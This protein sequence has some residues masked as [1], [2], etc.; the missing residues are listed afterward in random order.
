M[1]VETTLAQEIRAKEGKEKYDAACKRLLSQKSILAWILKSCVEE[2]RDCSIT[3]IAEKYIEGT[4]QISVVPVNPDETNAAPVI[5]GIRTE[6]ATLT[7]GTIV[8]DIRFVAYVPGGGEPI[9]L[10]INVEAQSSTTGYPLIMRAIFYCCRMIS[11]QYGTEFTNSHYEKIKKV[12]SIWISTTPRKKEKNTINRYRITEENLIG[13]AKEL[14]RH[15]DLMTVIVIGLGDLKDKECTDILRLLSALLS[16]QTDA[17]QTKQIMQ[18]EFG[19]PMTEEMERAVTEMCNLSQG[20][21]NRGIA[22]GLAKGRVEGRVEG[23]AEGQ[24][25]GVMDS[26]YNLMDS[27]NWTIE[28]AM[29]ALKISEEDRQKYQ[30]L[31]SKQ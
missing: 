2:Y 14:V 20:V 1:E 9:Q 8:Y 22:K 23:R 19:I 25:K 15:Y 29:T 4:P 10:I 28:Q 31:L 12:Y 13:H 11:A 7:E 24:A 21:E 5:R 26:L 27:M 18:E 6:D 3:D 30:E 16:S 17:A